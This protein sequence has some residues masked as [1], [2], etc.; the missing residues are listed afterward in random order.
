MSEKTLKELRDD[1]AAAAARVL[2]ARHAAELLGELDDL[3]ATLA[4]QLQIDG[5]P[6]HDAALV[7]ALVQRYAS[8]AH[9]DAVAARKAAERTTH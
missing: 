5:I 6:Q 1:E 4:A 3:L 2:V 7:V 8:A 9:R